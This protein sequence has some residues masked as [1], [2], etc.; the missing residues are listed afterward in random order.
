[1]NGNSS[2]KRMLST[3]KYFEELL[4]SVAPLRGPCSS[5]VVARSR[6]GS[7]ARLRAVVRF[8]ETVSRL[9]GHLH[10]LHKG[11]VQLFCGPPMEEINATPRASRCEFCEVGFQTGNADACCRTQCMH[12]NGGGPSSRTIKNCNSESRF[13]LP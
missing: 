8:I 12:F 5:F 4:K 3:F 1:M 11:L 7:I 9:G 2:F 13:F 6:G 10:E